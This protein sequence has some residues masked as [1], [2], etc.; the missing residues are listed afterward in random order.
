MIALAWLSVGFI[1]IARVYYTVAKLLIM[2]RG[3]CPT[4]AH[5]RGA[6]RHLAG[7]TTGVGNAPWL[8]VVPV[9]DRGFFV[10]L[11]VWVGGWVGATMRWRDVQ[12]PLHLRVGTVASEM[13]GELAVCT[14]RAFAKHYFFDEYGLGRVRE[15]RAPAR[16][17]CAHTNDGLGRRRTVARRAPAST[18]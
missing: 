2:V 15:K 17:F 14:Y 3:C 10:C 6:C 4:R 1:P 5:T 8:T 12:K 13:R 18:A 11:F 7:L 16:Q 9:G